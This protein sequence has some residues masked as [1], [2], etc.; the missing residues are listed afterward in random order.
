MNKIAAGARDFAD[1][2][3]TFAKNHPAQALEAAGLGAVGLGYIA[4]KGAQATFGMLTGATAL[5]GSAA[6][7]TESAAALN[8]AAAKLALT[9]GGPMS[10]LPPV[11]PIPPGGKLD[12]VALIARFPT[13]AWALA[14][15]GMATT[16]DIQKS[17]H[18]RSWDDIMREYRDRVNLIRPDTPYMFTL[19][20]V[21]SALGLPTSHPP[22]LGSDYV[23]AMHGSADI[24]V[25]VTAGDGLRAEIESVVNNVLGFLHINGAPP[26]GTAG[27]TGVAMP[28]ALP[29]GP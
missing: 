13:L 21:R 5:K 15:Y 24:T 17:V 27:S 8:G 1:V 22:G 25:K 19:D 4:L 23:A 18:G 14:A 29:A 3:A 10:K 7:L 16:E 11:A 9:P 20:G 6:A 12:P 2:Y 28:E 26:T